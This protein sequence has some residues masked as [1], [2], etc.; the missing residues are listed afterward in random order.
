MSLPI[1]DRDPLRPLPRGVRRLLP[2][3]LLQPLHLLRL[4]VP[5]LRRVL[6][7]RW[8]DWSGL[9][10]ALVEWES[11]FIRCTISGGDFFILLGR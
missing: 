1:L 9:R 3:E 4:R 7:Q 10:V 8:S 6:L 5:D 11:F 2:G